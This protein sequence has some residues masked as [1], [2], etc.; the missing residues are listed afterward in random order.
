MPRQIS[1]LFRIRLLVPQAKLSVY[2]D[3]S[4]RRNLSVLR[5]KLIVLPH[6]GAFKM[7]VKLLKWIKF[8]YFRPSTFDPRRTTLDN[9][10]NSNY[11]RQ[12]HLGNEFHCL[13]PSQQKL[14]L[15]GREISE[16]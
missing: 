6:L 7:V 13:A 2:I 16:I 8:Y 4:H 9:Y 5:A 15:L 1:H 10:T 3:Y 12:L 14:F 11:K